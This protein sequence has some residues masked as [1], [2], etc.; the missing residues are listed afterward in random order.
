MEE[1]SPE[2]AQPRAL[3]PT[4]STFCRRL[5]GLSADDAR[6]WIASALVDSTSSQA[7]RFLERCR[8]GDLSV[9][10]CCFLAWEQCAG[11]GRGDREWRS[12]AGLGL[13]MTLVCPD[14]AHDSIQQLPLISAVEVARAVSGLL[15][16]KVGVK[17]PNDVL[18][19][20]RKLAGI[21]V[22]ASSR[23]SDTTAL[24]GIGINVHHTEE[25]LPLPTAT[26]L[27][28]EGAADPDV[29]GLAVHVA[30]GLSG[31]LESKPSMAEVVEQYRT[32]SEHAPGDRLRCRMGEDAVEGVFAGF[33]E[34]GSLRLEVQGRILT[35]RSSEIVET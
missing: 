18:A 11:R 2:A 19:G 1:R 26:S 9:L 8:S 28:L 24:V 34:D 35:L 13:Y 20:G 27:A 25:T 6:S 12:A 3:G 33:A 17:W 22:E 23:G 16:A 32:W 31:T 15:S 4:F 10:P 21:L 30:R 14:L 5:A 29:A 7:R